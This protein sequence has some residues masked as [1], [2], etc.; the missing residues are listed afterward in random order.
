MALE[1]ALAY[2]GVAG[3]AVEGTPVAPVKFIP[4]QTL[5]SAEDMVI[6]TRRN[7]FNRDMS[8][9]AKMKQSS[10]IKFKTYLYPDS[11]AF[12]LCAA[13]GATDTVSGAGDPY[14]HTM[15]M[16]DTQP[17]LV[18]VE[19]SIANGQVI[20]RIPDGRVDKYSLNMRGGEFI[21]LDCEIPAHNATRQ[22]SAASVAFETDRPLTFLDSVF[23][24]TTLDMDTADVIECKLDI[25]NG[26]K[27][28]QPAGSFAPRYIAEGREINLSGKLL[29]AD[30]KAFREINWG[31]DTGTTAVSAPTYE[32]S[33][34]LVFDLGG[35]PDHQI[36]IT[37]T[38][39]VVKT[40]KPN[41]DVNAAVQMLDW[42]NTGI[43]NSTAAAL[44]TGVA[45]NAYAT[46]YSA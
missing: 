41:F 37:V 45:K 3:Q 42:T 32:A 36:Q 11:G 18:T 20:Q 13:L 5:D 30:D 46:A 28:Y 34:V 7:G 29:W 33:I 25:M 16:A 14:T 6:A 19:T 22:A 27:G 4:W 15:P 21:D 17:R 24:F 9:A 43:R 39:V 31:S 1:N 35:T 2:L 23:T 12:L 8:I 44:L 10:T 38:N 40:G 26:V